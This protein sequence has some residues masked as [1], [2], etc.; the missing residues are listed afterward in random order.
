MQNTGP[1]GP[2]LDTPRLWGVIS[3]MT[4]VICTQCYQAS[5]KAA[6]SDAE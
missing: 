6:Y 3:D 2:S 1:P 4:L 5:C